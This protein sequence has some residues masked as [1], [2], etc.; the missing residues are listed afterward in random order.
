MV[1]N[2]NAV[3][4]VTNDI[5]THML[6]AMEPSQGSCL[7]ILINK[8]KDYHS[9]NALMGTVSMLTMAYGSMAPVLSN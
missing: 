2:A 6:F 8:K 5:S 7:E 4:I 9:A 1:T 3:S